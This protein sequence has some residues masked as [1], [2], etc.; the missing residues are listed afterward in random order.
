MKRFLSLV[1]LGLMSGTASAQDI[2]ERLSLQQAVEIAIRNNITVAQSAT[3]VEAADI[4]RKQAKAN[5]L[6][7]LNAD[8]NYGWNNGRSI[9]PFQNIYVNQQL[10]GS[11]VSVSGNWVLFNG[12]QVQNNIK[13]NQFAHEA[14][15]MELQQSKDQLTINVIIAYLQVLSGEDLLLN[16]ES[17]ALVT[18]NQVERLQVLVSEGARGQ[19]QLSDMKGQYANDQV[20]I[21]TAKNSLDIARITLC[22]LMNI[23]TSKTIQLE[24]NDAPFPQEPYGAT[25]EIIYANGKNLPGIKAMDLRV[26]SAKRA[27]AVEKGAFMPRIGLYGNLFSNYSS[28]AETRTLTGTTDVTTDNYVLVNS[29]KT[30]VI[31]PQS[32]FASQSISY[33]NQMKNNIGSGFGVAASIPIFNN[34]RTKYRVDQAKVQLKAA[35]LDKSQADLT[36]RQNIEQAYANMESAYNRYK[37][38]DEQYRE[39]AESFRANEIRFNEGV[40][41][42]FEYLQAKNNLDR[43]RLNL[44]QI[45]YEYIFRTKI[46][47]Y[48][49]G[50]LSF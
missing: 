31:S 41:N 43:A 25:P 36:L 34:L 38:V 23:P 6:P 8:F 39:Y 15:K 27:I 26:E 9:D 47:D 48:F 4:N 37:A 33:N 18:K 16:L 30:N 5:M 3:R 24:R 46:L 28:A 29:V 22:Q 11:N 44:T 50:K 32:Q 14:T 12:L 21:V 19:Y 45:R 40:I 35:E 42:S 2:P 10:Q 1:F 17:Q 13:Q 7:S 20:S 49:Q